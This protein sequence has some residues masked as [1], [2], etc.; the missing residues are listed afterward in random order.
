MQHTLRIYDT[1]L[2]AD[3]NRSYAL[4]RFMF[5]TKNEF[6]TE[7]IRKGLQSFKPLDDGNFSG[8]PP[9]G[10]LSEA[11]AKAEDLKALL[12][13]LISITETLTKHIGL[14]EKLLSSVYNIILS[15]AAG[16]PLMPQKVEDGFYDD[17]PARFEKLLNKLNGFS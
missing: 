10:T 7:L 9:A 11:L 17:L 6:L 14:M 15:Q 3:L 8:M 2:I 1:A 13:E 4:Y 12:S 16:Y 5:K